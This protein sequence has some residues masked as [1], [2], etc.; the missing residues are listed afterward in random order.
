M[1]QQPLLQ[2]GAQTPDPL[3][4]DSGAASRLKCAGGEFHDRYLSPSRIH[5]ALTLDRLLAVG[6]GPIV[7]CWPSLLVVTSTASLQL[8]PA[9]HLSSEEIVNIS[10]QLLTKVARW[11]SALRRQGRSARLNGE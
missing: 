2:S 6:H 11:H 8:D 9:A 5:V 4:A 7:G 1:R 3:G 10:S